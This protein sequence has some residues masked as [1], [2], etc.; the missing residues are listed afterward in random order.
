M[1]GPA[2]LQQPL[3]MSDGKTMAPAWSIWFS[4]VKSAIAGAGGATTLTGDV[5]GSGTGS[6]ATAVAKIGG[7]AVGADPLTQYALLAARSGTNS[8]TG[9]INITGA[10]KSAAAQTTVN[11]S[12]SGTAAFSQ[13]ESGSSY[14][15]VVIYCNALLGTATYNF[16]VSFSQTPQILSQSLG[17]LVTALSGSAVTVTGTTST[18]FIELS[19]Y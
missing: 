13:P 2:P 7:V 18:G 9:N 4:Q 6:F 10:F 15:R 5:T 17:G 14:K 19:G 11:G 3:F 16:P 1:I 8:F 12:T